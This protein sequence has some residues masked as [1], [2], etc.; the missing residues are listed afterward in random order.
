MTIRKMAADLLHLLEETFR[1]G[2]VLFYG[3]LS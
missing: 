3:E 1:G 2:W